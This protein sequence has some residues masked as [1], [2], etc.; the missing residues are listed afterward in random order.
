MKM[1]DKNIGVLIK[2]MLKIRTEKE[3]YDFLQGILTPKELL[4]IPKRL[5]IVKMLKKGITQHEIAKELKVG[6]ATITRGSKEL[7]KGSF[8]NV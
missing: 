1:I 4:E 3:M 8:Q 2:T 7:L 6:I 5:T